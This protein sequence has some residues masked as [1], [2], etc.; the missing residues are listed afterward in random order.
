MLAAGYEQKQILSYFEYS[1]GEFVL[2]QPPLRGVN[3]KFVWLAPVLGLA[4]RQA[5]SSEF[6]GARGPAR[7]REVASL[8]KRFRPTSPDRTPSPPIRSSRPMSS[9]CGN[10]PTAG[11]KA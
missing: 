1:Y 4:R 5:S 10:S 7:G 9:E 2:L 11:R 3:F 6:S 8:L